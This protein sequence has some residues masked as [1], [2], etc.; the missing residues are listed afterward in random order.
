M[1]FEGGWQAVS[2]IMKTESLKALHIH[3]CECYSTGLKLLKSSETGFL[4]MGM[5]IAYFKQ[6]GMVVCN[7]EVLKIFVKTSM[8]WSAQA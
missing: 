5:I 4:G 1:T 8:S 7:K 3:W 2:D 6:G